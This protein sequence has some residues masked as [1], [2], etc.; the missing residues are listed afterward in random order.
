PILKMKN[1]ITI[2][3]FAFVFGITLVIAEDI[4][5]ATVSLQDFARAMGDLKSA[6]SLVNIPQANLDLPQAKPLQ[7][8]NPSIEFKDLSFAYSDGQLLFDKL[9]LFVQPGEKIGLVGHSGAGKSSLVNLLL[10]YF[11]YT[12]GQI[13]IDGQEISAITQDSLRE[14]IAMIP[15]DTMLFHRSIMENIR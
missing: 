1:L 7:I 9:N 12:K 8:E 13:L 6:L 15:Q 11:T 4:W 2:G 14:Q 3:D 10:R 5:H